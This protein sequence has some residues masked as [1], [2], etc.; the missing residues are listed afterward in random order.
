M[1][2]P[3]VLAL[4]L[5]SSLTAVFLVCLAC[6]STLPPTAAAPTWPAAAP[7][8]ETVAQTY[9]VA[10]DGEDVIPGGTSE[11]PWRT[12][13]FAVENVAPG[14]TIRVRSGTYDGC[15]IENSGT[16]GAW[17][18]L[19]ADDGSQVVVDA[20]GP[21]N[22]HGSN[23]EIETWEGDGVVAYWIVEGLEVAGAPS[24]GVDV[25]GSDAAHS[26]HIVIR[27]NTVHDCGLAT[28]RTGIFTAFVDDATIEQNESHHNGEHGVYCSNSGD[29]PVIR[30]NVLHHNVGCGVHMNGDASMDGDGVI[31]GGLV[32]RNVIYENGSGGGSAINMDGVT[33][34]IVRN[35]LLYDNH[36]GG[37][38]IFQHD[39]AVCSQRNRVLNNTILMPA[40][41]RWAVNVSQAGCVDNHLYNNVIYTAHSWRG[42]IVIPTPDLAGFE[43]D[44]NVLVDRL[45]ADGESSV[46][47]LAEWQ[48]LGYDS[49][50]F[51]ATP[52]ELFVDPAA[53]DYHLRAGSPAVDAGTT[54][55]DVTD[56]LE[57]TLRPIGAAY[58]IGALEQ[59]VRVWLPLVARSLEGG[60]TR[61]LEV[62]FS[63]LCWP[64]WVLP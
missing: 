19:R 34:T 31:S 1:T 18:T 10:T 15:R 38:A 42:S 14:D 9:Y 2:G 3:K 5:L 45:S 27:R 25:R 21:Q 36:A 12:I 39:G 37:I 58:D 64:S 51:I 16:A 57:G 54:L 49:H 8:G 26:H 50:S 62:G 41:G 47:S 61:L 32:E 29:R 55:G 33:D 7:P 46:I 6:Q 23:V 60:Q 44:Y 48:A 35:N 30:D 28:G 22:T 40:D 24:W 52:G 56:D 20:P 13:Q 17:I 11:Q 59:G 63:P 4:P 53:D 43:S